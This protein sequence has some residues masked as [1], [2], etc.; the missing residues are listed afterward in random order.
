MDSKKIVN[1]NSPSVLYVLTPPLSGVFNSI[2]LS[3]GDIKA[4]IM[5]GARVEEVLSNGTTVKLDLK[6]YNKDNTVGLDKLES[7]KNDK[8]EPTIIK[9]VEVKEPVC[10]EKE[11]IQFI[12]IPEIEES[13]P[14]ELE[15]QKELEINNI[16]EIVEETPIEE[17]IEETLVEEIVEDNSNIETQEG[18]VEE[19]PIEETITVE[20]PQYNNSRKEKRNR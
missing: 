18:I 7:P 6:N 2:E 5:Q 19:T 9:T 17:V 10:T 13:E 16:E 12:P 4:C 20:K 11:T 8:I 1:I 3:L 15:P 14:V